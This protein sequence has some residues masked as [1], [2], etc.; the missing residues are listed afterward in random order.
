[1]KIFTRMKHMMLLVATV[2]C[3]G[4]AFA[5]EYSPVW[6]N[7]FEDASTFSQGWTWRV[8]GRYEIIQTTGY[9]GQSNSALEFSCLSANNGEDYYYSPVTE[10]SNAMAEYVDDYQL[11]FYYYFQAGNNNS[12]TITFEFSSGSFK[13]VAPKSAAAEIFVNDVTTSAYVD[14]KTWCHIYVKSKGGVTSLTITDVSG[15]NVYV[16]D[17]AIAESAIVLTKITLNT[18]RYWSYFRLD[19]MTLSAPGAKEEISTPSISITKVDGVKRTITIG[20]GVGTVGTV[21]S[22]TYYTTDNS[23]PN[24]GNGTLYEAPFEI[25]ATSTNKAISYLPDGTASEVAALEVEAGTEVSLGKD[26]INVTGFAGDGDFLNPVISY[27]YNQNSVLL[28]PEVSL[29]VT[30]NDEPIELPYTVTESGTIS[31]TVTAEGYA[32]ATEEYTL[33]AAYAK[34]LHE[35]F[36]AIA[37]ED[38]QEILGDSWTVTEG[39]GRWAFWYNRTYDIASTSVSGNIGIGNFVRT[40]NAKNLV[41]GYGFGRNTSNGANSYWVNDAESDD[42]ALY[43][44]DESYGNNTNYAKHVVAYVD[45]NTLK[46]TTYGP[47]ALAKASVYRP[48]QELLT[49]T[50][51]EDFTAIGGYNSATYIG[52][53]IAEGAYGTICLPFTPDE[54]SLENYTFFKMESVGADAI[55]FV[56]E[57]APVAN[58]PYIY[59]L[60]E[61]KTA[62]AITGG[63]TVVS[64]TINDVKAGDWTMKGSFTAQSIATEGAGAKYYGYVAADNKIVKANKTLTVL[65]YRAYFTAP[66]NAAAVALRITRG[67]ETTEIT[68]ADL[69]VQPAT[70]I[71]DLAGRR[72]EKMEKGVYIVN[73]KKVIR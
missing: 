67:D 68:A 20:A 8:G 60:K 49:V 5:Q 62:T 21:A 38:V 18:G 55:N 43:E 72:V 34:N 52:R 1:M 64:T 42:I 27:V 51:G 59:C 22:A 33:A 16:E 50:E 69:D 37:K 12:S 3:T 36:T 2:L 23:E 46:Y 19:D 66:V 39:A 57:T 26:I 29:T 61:G 30:F 10:L 15:E 56:E 11:D 54:A 47:V 17:V 48:V 13:M 58:T 45:N 9:D 63:A 73:G 65:P 25:S 35:D 53:T 28:S 7:N 31:A 6:V 71:Y 24:E 40:D 4:S 44:V 70:V 14:N 41:I 32:S